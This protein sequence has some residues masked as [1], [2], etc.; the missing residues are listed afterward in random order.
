MSETELAVISAVIHAVIY[1]PLDKERIAEADALVKDGYLKKTYRGYR[2]TIQG[3]MAYH[4]YL[5]ANQPKEMMMIT[6]ITKADREALAQNG[7]WVNADD[8]KEKVSEMTDRRLATL[9]LFLIRSAKREAHSYTAIGYEALGFLHGEMAL[10]LMESEV[11]AWDM[12]SLE[13][14]VDEVLG[15]TLIWSFI[16]AEWEQRCFPF[17]TLLQFHVFGQQCDTWAD[18]SYL[19]DG[20]HL[21]G[22]RVTETLERRNR[23]Y[24]GENA[25]E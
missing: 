18:W 7:V 20:D 17:T 3:G 5:A 15:E 19:F 21:I 23:V 13:D 4:E 2:I 14:Q 9:T 10:D 22:Q 25:D 8:Q 11:D 24:Q 6:K 16:E 12:L 1:K